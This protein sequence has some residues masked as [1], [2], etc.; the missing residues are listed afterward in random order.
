LFASSLL[1]RS[2]DFLSVAAILFSSAAHDHPS[3]PLF[4]LGPDGKQL[5]LIQIKGLVIG[6][7]T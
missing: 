3:P 7:L 1:R 4:Q 2:Q 5:A 6:P